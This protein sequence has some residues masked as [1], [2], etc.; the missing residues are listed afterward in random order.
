MSVPTNVRL[1]HLSAAS[2]NLIVECLNCSAV[3]GNDSNVALK[4]SV[5]PT[6]CDPPPPSDGLNGRKVLPKSVQNKT[7]SY[8]WSNTALSNPSSIYLCFFKLQYSC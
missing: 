3:I 6:C 5:A 7:F 8:F 2:P 4:N 1:N